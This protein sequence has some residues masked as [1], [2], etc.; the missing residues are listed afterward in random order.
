MLGLMEKEGAIWFLSNTCFLGMG[1]IKN[2]AVSNGDAPKINP[3]VK[4]ENHFYGICSEHKLLIADI[5]FSL[6]ISHFA[7]TSPALYSVF[8]T[9]ILWT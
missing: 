6:C 3:L 5:Y 7:T 4:V 9:V 8:L 1:W 2:K